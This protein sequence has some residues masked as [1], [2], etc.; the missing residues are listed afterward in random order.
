MPDISAIA[1]A[2]T[3][4]NT[5]K[6]IAQTMVGLHDVKTLQAK[7]IEFN[8][9]IIDAQT[10]I[11]L[12]NE[13]RA[14]LIETIRNLEK[15]LTDLKAWETEKQRYQ[16]TDVGDGTFAHALKQSMSA[17]EPPHYI[18]ANCYEHAKKSILNHMQMPGGAHSLA[19]SAC[20][21]KLIIR[22]GYRP[23]AYVESGAEKARAA[24]EPCPICDTGR[25]KI[26][27]SDVFLS[28]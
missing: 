27:A 13:E 3:S 14:A 25:L 22:H 4:F 5:L 20:D 18:C 16:L 10:K 6:N 26:T 24:L 23:A 12:V 21:A 17:S 8:N 9:A 2:L 1:A 11:F 7:V 28:A 19:C 15:E